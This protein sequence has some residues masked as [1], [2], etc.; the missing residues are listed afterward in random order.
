MIGCP[1]EAVAIAR[2]EKHKADPAL[3]HVPA[4]LGVSWRRHKLNL[5]GLAMEKDAI[6]R[7]DFLS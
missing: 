3:F 1:T 7:W 5:S 6:A 4:C 2:H